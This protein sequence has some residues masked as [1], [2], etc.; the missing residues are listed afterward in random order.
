LIFSS[1]SKQKDAYFYSCSACVDG[2]VFIRK[3]NEGPDEEEKPQIF[4]RILLALH[5]I[6]DGELVHP[7][8]CWH[9]HK[10]V[11]MDFE[12]NVIKIKFPSHHIFHSLHWY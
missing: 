1:I 5:I 8:V 9:P 2:C 12:V 4:E 10:Q 6:A 11:I 3:I 7:R